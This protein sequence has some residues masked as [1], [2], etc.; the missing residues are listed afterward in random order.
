MVDAHIASGA[1]ASVAAIRQPINLADQFGVI[2][3]DPSAPDR[4]RAFLEKPKRPAGPAGQP[5]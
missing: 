2:D 5:R 4:I 1:A 3:V